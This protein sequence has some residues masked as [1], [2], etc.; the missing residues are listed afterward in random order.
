MRKNLLFKSFAILAMA[1][2]AL[3]CAKEQVGSET[4][5]GEEIN[6]TFNALLPEGIKTRAI[7]DGTTANQLV[8]AVYEAGSDAELI[9]VDKQIDISTTVEFKLVKGKTYDFVFWAQNKKN[10]YYTIDDLKNIKISYDGEANDEGRDAFFATRKGL[11]VTGAMNETVTLHRPFAQ[12]NFGASDYAAAEG[13]GFKPTLSSFTATGAA[14]VFCPF[15]E[16]GATEATVSYTAKELPKE[17]L[18]VKIGDK[19][20]SYK[21]LAMNYFIPVGKIGEK[22]VSDVSATFALD[23]QSNKTVKISAPNAPVRSNYRTNIL[24]SLLTDQTNFNVVIAP[25][26][27]EV[28]DTDPDYSN[29]PDYIYNQLALAFANGGAVK[30]TEDVTISTPLKIE[31]GVNV[32]LDLNGKTIKFNGGKDDAHCVLFRVNKGTLTIDGTGNIEGGADEHDQ[33][34]LLMASGDESKLIIKN[35]NFKIGNSGTQN[36]YDLVY[37]LNNGQVEIYDGKFEIEST[38]PNGN[39]YCLNL[40]NSKPGTITVYGGTFVN[41]DPA[42]GDDNL[43]GNFVAAG[44]KSTNTTTDPNGTPVY[45]VTKVD[46]TEGLTNVI[47]GAVKGQTTTV[48]LPSNSN[49]TLDSGIAHEGDKSRNITFVGDGTQTIDV[50]TKAVSAENGML[51]YQRG[52]SFTFKNMKIQAGEGDF[53]GIVCDELTYENCTIKGKLTLYGKATFIDC[54][55]ENDMANQYS[56]WTWGGTDVWFEGCTFNTNGKAILL[57]G[58]SSNKKPTNLIVTDC[59]FND[60]EKDVVQKAAIEIGDS[61]GSTYSLV[62]TKCTVNGFAINP[63]GTNTNSTLWANKNSMDAE[64]LSVTIDGTKVL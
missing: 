51:N 54:T 57:Y 2:A 5:D 62:A 49:F 1:T 22:Q 4:P 32:Y 38:R 42:I 20:N 17:D 47:T 33:R 15:T 56:I 3:S 25:A 44:Y 45:A 31:N 16:E 10:G 28:E 30:L 29:S 26:F 14:T 46:L 19:E 59:I 63:E 37:A 53:D 58:G 41:Y 12:V 23:A 52:S 36:W 55:F 21:W 40:N 60:S 27:N 43:G 48:A 50:I 9:R 6:V 61:Y 18:K 13:A 8:V 35:G 34:V 11:L 7:G 24:G 39:H 64:H